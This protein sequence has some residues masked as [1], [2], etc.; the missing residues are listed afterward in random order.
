MKY[1]GCVFS[2]CWVAAA[3]SAAWSVPPAKVALQGG[4]I[5]PVVGEEIPKGTL[6]I[7]NGF[8]KAVGENV[9]IPY[10][11]MVVDVSGKVLFPG[12]IDPHS[13]RG[14]DIANENLPVT[15]FLDVYDAIDPSRLYFEDALRDGVTSVHVIVANNCVIGGLG[16]V[17]HPIGLTPDEMTL[18][19]ST[20]LK[21]S[22]SPKQGFDRMTQMAMLRE[23]FREL[24]DY[25]DKLA[26]QKYEESLKKKDEEIEVGPDEA[27]KRGKELLRIEDYDD[28]HRNLWKLTRGQLGAFVYCDRASDVARGIAL[29][30]EQGFFEKT[31]LV[32]G[33]DCFKA[34]DEIMAAG[35]PVVL[36]SEL[37]YRERDPITGKISETFVPKVFADAGVA[38]SLQPDPDAS[39]AERYLNYQAARCVRG[40]I[41]RKTALE[42]MT[43]NPANAVEIG[44]RVGSL[45]PGK[46]ANVVVF[47]GDPLDFNSWVDFVY[48]KGIKAYERATDVRLKQLLGDEIK[49]IAVKPEDAKEKDGDDAKN[50]A[51]SSK[52]EPS[53]DDSKDEK[54]SESPE[55][56]Q[57]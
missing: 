27:I 32:L 14:L 18:Q 47:S 1:F 6:L 49:E 20:G 13:S 10:D 22:V 16:R 34:I 55:P 40:G 44:D 4:R 7:E 21:I 39:L 53:N 2:A 17:V 12:M 41:A 37:L 29:A 42:S 28:A 31:T 8:I 19:S 25:H 24:A 9:E 46:V 52:T 54:P 45:E 43:I 15:P 48:I 38:F 11:A 23:T 36:A 57:P 51:G 26:E 35:R 56:K 30:K 50:D 33:A 3:S 5:I